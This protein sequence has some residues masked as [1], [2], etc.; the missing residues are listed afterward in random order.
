M[1]KYWFLGRDPLGEIF[2]R[3]DLP[4]RHFPRQVQ[5]VQ[6]APPREPVA[7]VMNLGLLE[8]DQATHLHKVIPSV[9]RHL[10]F[11][12]LGSCLVATRR[13]AD[14][15]RIIPDDDHGRMTQILEL[16][17]FAQR[18]GV[19][20]VNVDARRIDSVLHPEGTVL[21]DRS[22]QLLDEFSLGNDPVDASL[23]DRELFGNIPHATRR[24]LYVDQLTRPFDVIQLKQTIRQAHRRG[25]PPLSA[26]R[27]GTREL[28][29]H[30]WHTRYLRMGSI[31]CARSQI[32]PSHRAECKAGGRP[33][34]LRV[35]SR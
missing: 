15:R 21:A 31:E 35:E 26:R 9:G 33:G 34:A 12:Q 5:H 28:R 11:G 30:R 7:V 14:E 8:I 27:S 25:N 13:V 24:L 23:Q 1:K 17:Q 22:L 19:P 4:Q 3:G 29:A 20:Q 18:Y 10:L 16:P 32:G 2:S 6:E